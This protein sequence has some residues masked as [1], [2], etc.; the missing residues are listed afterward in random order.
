MSVDS[1]LGSNYD[2]LA[3]CSDILERVLLDHNNGV[4][5]TPEQEL[6]EQL[7]MMFAPLNEDAS[8]DAIVVQ[9]LLRDPQGKPLVDAV[10]L[11]TAL[12]TGAIDV[13]ILDELRAIL[14]EIERQRS[15]ILKRRTGY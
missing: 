4:E 12:S 8:L 2:S 5:T 3:V 6:R 1:L 14:L 15:E 10:K 9:S 13:A 7:S 11:R